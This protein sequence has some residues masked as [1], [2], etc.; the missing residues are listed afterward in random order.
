MHEQIID[1]DMDLTYNSYRIRELGAKWQPDGVHEVSANQY[2]FKGGFKMHRKRNASS[3]AKRMLALTLVI[4]FV[5]ASIPVSQVNAAKKKPSLKKTKATVQVGKTFKIG[6]KNKN[7]KAAYSYKTS[8]KKVATVSKAGKVKGVKTGKAKIT[9]SQKLKKKTTKVGVLNV[10]VTA[11][12]QDKQEPTAEPNVSTTPSTAPSASTTPGTSA[13]PGTSQTP[14]TSGTPIP[15]G[16]PVASGSPVPT[17][18]PIPSVEG[19]AVAYGSPAMGTTIDPIWDDVEEFSPKFKSNQNSS[20]EVAYKLLWDERSIYVLATVTKGSLYANSTNPQFQ[21]SVEIMLDENFDRATTYQDDDALYRVNFRNAR[22]ATN[23]PI[24]RLYSFAQETSTGYVVQA[25]IALTDEALNDKEMG[26]ELQVNEAAASFRS[27][28]Q[29]VFDSTGQ[30]GTNPSLMGKVTLTGKGADDKVALDKYTLL[31]Y[32]EYATG[33]LTDDYV[34]GTEVD[35]LVANAKAALDK[36]GVTQEELDEACEEMKTAETLLTDDNLYSAP[37]GFVDPSQIQESSKLPDVLTMLDGTKVTTP[38]QWAERREEIKSIVEYYGYGKWRDGEDETLDYSISG[39][40]MSIAIDR[41]GKTTANLTTTITLPSGTAPEGGWPVVVSFGGLGQSDYVLQRGY[42]VISFTP[43]EVAADGANRTGEFYKLYPY[44]KTWN[45]QTGVLM[46][47]GWGA[48]KVL[49]ALE[50]GAG[51]D[52]KISTENTVIT[53]VSRY[54]KGAL[55]AGAFE[56][57]FKVTMPT[58][59]G[60]AG[61]SIGRYDSNSQVYDM[62]NY[63]GATEW[64]VNTGNSNNPQPFT[65]LRSE[66]TGWMIANYQKFNSYHHLPYDQ[67]FLAAMCAGEDRHLFLNGGV[68]GDG[69]TNV[70]GLYYTFEAT[71]PVFE[72][73][74]VSKNIM[75]NIHKDLHGHEQIDFI[76]LLNYMDYYF[77][78]KTDISFEGYPMNTGL[79]T[80]P[81]NWEEFMASLHLTMFSK[82]VSEENNAVYEARKNKAYNRNTGEL[83]D[84]P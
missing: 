27:G 83:T 17:G 80:I 35:A 5:L 38:A 52:L 81:T 64:V 19:L 66:G 20:T 16:T 71:L 69:W 79:P 25:R 34:N 3:I 61:A 37:E 2:Y 44:G 75:I 82:E 72:L 74:D 8:K 78:D 42:A 62:S 43:N 50:A 26:F 45:S 11:K 57:R 1:F 24:G 9:V 55:V 12:S 67:H 46:A 49:D 29:N 40:T 65:Q 76:R 56:E 51:E 31:G 33:F 48:S 6:I 15:T 77:Y 14:G 22:T 30:A 59:S 47:W 18:T 32:Y 73:L 28:Y 10:T 13:T 84:L 7:K 63:E 60:A 54:G 4:A 36:E 21:D 41:P 39:N 23:G 53:G 70:P 58:S 68:T